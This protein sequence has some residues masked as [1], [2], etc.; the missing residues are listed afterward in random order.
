MWKVEGKKLN[1][2]NNLNAL[3]LSEIVK[4]EIE[5]DMRGNKQLEKFHNSASTLL[6]CACHGKMTDDLFEHLL[7]C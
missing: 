5:L 2:F 7:S 6:C 1:N 4:M 3:I